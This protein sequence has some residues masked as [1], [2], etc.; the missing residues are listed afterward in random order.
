M[1]AS[2]HY[3]K[4]A[5]VDL[6]TLEA[7]CASHEVFEIR[8]YTIDVINDTKKKG[9]R[10]TGIVLRF[11]K[12]NA[13]VKEFYLDTEG[14]PH[15]P[16]ETAIEVGIIDFSVYSYGQLIDRDSYDVSSGEIVTGAMKKKKKE[17]DNIDEII[18]SFK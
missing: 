1:I 12:E 13:A 18:E 8:I 5:D 17:R 14:E 7:S 9:G 2:I 6:K 11:T 16:N 15:D 10:I 4:T 3:I